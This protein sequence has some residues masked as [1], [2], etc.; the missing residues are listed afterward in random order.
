MHPI[1]GDLSIITDDDLLILD[2][3][4]FILAQGLGG[5][6]HTLFD[7]IIEILGGGSFNF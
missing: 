1:F 6:Y 4:R 3:G 5:T 2:P 7:G